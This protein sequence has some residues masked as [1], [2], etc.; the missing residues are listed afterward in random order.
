MNFY[1]RRLA[2]PAAGTTQASGA[3]L[4]LDQV[5]PNYTGSLP[6]YSAANYCVNASIQFYTPQLTPIGHNTRISENTFDPQLNSPHTACV[7]CET[8]FIG[9]YF[10]NTTRPMPSGALDYSTLTST[11]DDGTNPAHYQQQIVSTVPVP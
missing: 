9:D 7:S 4:K 6:P 1:D 8:T 3:G 5:N 2:C 11:Y 10:G